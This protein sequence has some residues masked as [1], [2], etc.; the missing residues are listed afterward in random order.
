[1]I[2][3]PRLP[4]VRLGKTSRRE[5]LRWSGGLV[6]GSALTGVMSAADSVTSPGEPARAW[7]GPPVWPPLEKVEA[8]LRDWAKK[9]PR[10]MRLD[11]IGRSVQGRTLYA[12]RL[13]D[14]NRDEGDKEH[15]LV[16]ALHSG[17]ERS[18]SNT[19]LSIIEW[20]LSGESAANE[21]LRRQV[22]VCLPI[23]DPD[24]Y[25]AGTVSP[26]YGAW[27]LDGPRDPDRSP[28]A[29]AV[30]KMMDLY[31][32][33]VHADIHGTNLEFARYV[34]IE[35]SG[36]SYSNL[37]LRPYHRE[38]IRQMDEA[39]L[40]EGYP[41]DLTESDAERLYWGPGLE[42]MKSKLWVGR[43][44][45]YAAIYCYYHYHTL[46]S[47]SEVAWERSGVLRHRRLLEIGN[48]TWPG[49]HYA[50]YPTR[51]VMA[52]THSMVTAYGQTA[53][54]RRRS[55]VELWN[56][57]HQMTFGIL[58][59]VVE[60][61]MMCVCATSSAATGKWLKDR[62]LKGMISG[63]R[64]HSGM[65]AEAIAQFSEGWPAGQ[66]SPE[67]FLA[68]QTG[69][70]DTKGTPAGKTSPVKQDDGPIQNGLCLR[71]RLPYRKARLIDLRVNGYP[72][73]P[74]ETD[75]FATWTARGCAYC[76]INVAPSRLRTHDLFVVT[77][78][79]DPCEKRGHWD[80]WRSL[81]DRL[82]PRK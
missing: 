4:N 70:S 49:E 2:H 66:N 77:C 73:S 1:M 29:M 13:T 42:P 25:V 31:Q 10:L 9:H 8:V 27:T 74:S 34:M 55:R 14:S 26:V 47:A 75:G 36:A 50:G 61:K 63:L 79:Y 82:E 41:S 40:A 59:P 43:P 15:A 58:D 7:F 56:K 6:V 71:I 3:E 21:I 20:L 22:V 52:N 46:V 28:E 5:F 62:S 53:S 24:R 69:A 19:V 11:D 44:N 67:P 33:E 57:L 60:G 30:K 76:Q 80:T 32:P 23:P 51:V 18:G 39:A 17:L 37:A 12:I 48:E 35:N 65:N 64:S 45:V 78:Q 54:A 72:V 16:T 38:I 81:P 68:L